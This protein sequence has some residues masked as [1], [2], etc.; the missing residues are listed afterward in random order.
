M[1]TATVALDP[2]FQLCGEHLQK[3]FAC[4]A[5]VPPPNQPNKKKGRRR[6]MPPRTCK[7]T[8]LAGHF[9][10]GGTRKLGLAPPIEVSPLLRNTYPY[11][12]A[13]ETLFSGDGVPLR[14]P[15]SYEP[16]ENPVT[17]S[18]LLAA[19]DGILRALDDGGAV[20]VHRP[21][22]AASDRYPP[23]AEQEL[24]A[25]LLRYAL[26]TGDVRAVQE[27]V[28]RLGDVAFFAGGTLP[29]PQSDAERSWKIRTMGGVGPYRRFLCEYPF[30]EYSLTTLLPHETNALIVVSHLIFLR[31]ARRIDPKWRASHLA[32]TRAAILLFRLLFMEVM[33]EEW[34]PHGRRPI[35]HSVIS[36]GNGGLSE[37]LAF[38]HGETRDHK[39]WGWEVWLYWLG[40]NDPRRVAEN[41]EAIASYEELS[42]RYRE[43]FDFERGAGHLRDTVHGFSKLERMTEEERGMRA[44]D[45][46]L[47]EQFLE[48]ER[49]VVELPI[50]GTAELV[51]AEGFEAYRE[52]AAK[53]EEHRSPS[54]LESDPDNF[55][56]SCPELDV[57]GGEDP[58]ALLH[59]YF[60]NDA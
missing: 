13:P 44:M 48:M 11:L 41:N 50:P 59:E 60:V 7:Q 31:L 45:S 3:K 5:E 21:A 42:D 2:L 20:F 51:E 53:E 27:E 35:R 24:P 37:E 10:P 56:L 4:D 33:L 57:N 14:R 55:L 1:S 19:A 22:Y 58:I 36:T 43:L 6:K 15:D 25:H 47:L 16:D 23:F 9:N 52:E 28:I 32:L 30:A 34:G 49:A 29:K 12:Y 40:H 26:D 38:L 46:A 8:R 39:L 54:M 18:V 17:L